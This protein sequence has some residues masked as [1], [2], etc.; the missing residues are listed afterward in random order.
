MAQWLSVEV[1]TNAV[2]A[3][4]KVQRTVI[5]ELDG[6]LMSQ[7]H[8]INEWYLPAD[9]IAYWNRFDMPKG[10]FSRIGDYLGSFGAGIP[11]LW[12]IDP[13]KAAKVQQAMRDKS[14]KLDIPPVEDHYWEEFGK[15]S[16]HQ[17]ATG[18]TQ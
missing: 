11:Q 17:M 8:Y 3:A 18:Q 6:I 7:Y 12:W 2:I 4:R 9:R 15:N 10:T 14:L 16:Q 1:F 13:E 5:R